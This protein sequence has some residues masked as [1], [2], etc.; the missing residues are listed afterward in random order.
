[1]KT[2]HKLCDDSVSLAFQCPYEPMWFW[3]V[4][5]EKMWLKYH[6]V[7]RTWNVEIFA[8]FSEVWTSD[9]SRATRRNSLAA[10]FAFRRSPVQTP[11]PGVKISAFVYV[12]N[13]IPDITAIRKLRLVEI[14]LPYSMLGYN[15]R[16]HLCVNPEYHFSKISFSKVTIENVPTKPMKCSLFLVKNNMCRKKVLSRAPI[17]FISLSP[18]VLSARS[19]CLFVSPFLICIWSIREAVRETAVPLHHRLRY[20]I[21]EWMMFFTPKCPLLA[22]R[23]IFA[24][25][26]IFKHTLFWVCVLL[27]CYKMFTLRKKIMVA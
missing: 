22:Y 15:M 1:M 13:I 18:A 6:W 25:S 27:P 8:P 16:S 9:L 5:V 12:L 20:K 21:P 26:N 17:Y 14:T 19:V 2:F 23:R 24:N 10:P 4:V 3:R 11:L 7:P